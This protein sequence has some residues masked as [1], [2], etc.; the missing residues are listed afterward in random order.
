MEGGEALHL[1]RS[2]RPTGRVLRLFKAWFW[3]PPR[4]HGDT[5]VDRR[6]SPLELLYDLVYVAVIS[7]AGHNVAEHVSLIRLAEFAVVFSLTWIAWTNG[8]MY[9]ELHGRSDGRTRTY[10]F[11]QMGILAILAVFA[12]G[13][14]DRAGPAFALTYSAFL[15][16]MTWLWYTVRRQDVI[17]RPELVHETGR[18]V[19]TMAVSA[20]LMFASAYLPAEARLNVWAVLVAG[21][22]VVLL[23]SR[24]GLSRGMTPTDS[25][26]ERF[27]TFTII[28]L[29]EV[30]FGVVDG[31]SLVNRDLKT[32]LTGMVALVVGF[33]F[34]WIYFDVV[35]GRLPKGD[36]RALANW[37]LGHHPVALSIAAAGV[38]MVSLIAH[39]HD[40]STPAPTAWLLSGAVAVGLIALILISRALSAAARL[41]AVYRPLEIAMAVG[42]VVSLLIGVARPAPWLFALLLVVVLSLVWAVA[43]RGFLLAGAS[44]AEQAE[45]K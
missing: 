38:G 14:G 18:Y 13:A 16:V 42:A 33:G 5:I 7:Q 22:V 12:R 40:A 9:L 11:A 30:V 32:I 27:G 1:N 21:W 43:M 24:I 15:A 26:V 29:G 41:A 34:W 2:T 37:I 36:G 45:R 23:W 4:P 20:A 8:S 19:V 17:E 28:V 6:V 31:L 3:Q 10:V 44:A 39:A 25:L 35:G